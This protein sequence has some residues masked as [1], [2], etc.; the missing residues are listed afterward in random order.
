MVEHKKGLGSCTLKGGRTTI[1]GSFSHAVPAWGVTSLK[2]KERDNLFASDEIR[3]RRRRVD[4]G[5]YVCIPYER[6]ECVPPL[7]IHHTLSCC[8]SSNNLSDP[9]AA[10]LS[11]SVGSCRVSRLHIS[12]YSS[13]TYS[14][15]QC[16]QEDP[17]RKKK[18]WAIAY[19][20]CLLKGEAVVLYSDTTE[21][22]I[23][24]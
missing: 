5:M 16:K 6:V 22:E 13:R 15:R 17:T 10:R 9:I 19:F 18:I 7:M 1:G 23:E 4:Y 20:F 14:T 2:K 3:K 11:I 21:R 24:G 12:Q 8:T